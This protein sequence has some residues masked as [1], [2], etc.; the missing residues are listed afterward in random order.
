MYYKM[1]SKCK[2]KVSVE[3]IQSEILLHSGCLPAEAFIQVM[4]LQ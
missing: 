1:R 3:S 2:A 4:E